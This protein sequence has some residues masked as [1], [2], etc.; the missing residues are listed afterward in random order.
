MFRLDIKFFIF[1]IKVKV[2][3]IEFN[4]NVPSE[5]ENEAVPYPWKSNKA[6]IKY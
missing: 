5:E 6:E 3:A 2:I 4:R 1:T